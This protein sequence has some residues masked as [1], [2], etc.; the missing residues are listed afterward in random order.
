MKKCLGVASLYV[1]LCKAVYWSEDRPSGRLV[2]DHTVMDEQ[3][4]DNHAI[5]MHQYEQA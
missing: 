5:I 3:L 4:S 1:S 2:R